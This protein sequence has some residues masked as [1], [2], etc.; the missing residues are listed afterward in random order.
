MSD[1]YELRRPFF[2]EDAAWIEAMGVVSYFVTRRRGDCRLGVMPA[3]PKTTL[4]LQSGE[5]A[6][7]GKVRPTR[8]CSILCQPWCAQTAQV[9]EVA[10][11]A[12]DGAV[13]SQ[14]HDVRRHGLHDPL[15][16][17]G[18]AMPIVH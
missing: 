17:L 6:G 4:A 11:V 15:V 16:L 10:R 12:G 8:R 14:P 2:H 18:I 7:F 13:F 1:V 5:I 9:I 3:Q